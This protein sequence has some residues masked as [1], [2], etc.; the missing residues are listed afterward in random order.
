FDMEEP[1]HQAPPPASSPAALR[2]MQLQRQAGTRPEQALQEALAELGVTFETGKR[3]LPEV[4]RSADIVIAEQRLAVF[5]D[6][7]FWHCCPEHA[8][9]PKANADFWREKLSANV[10]RD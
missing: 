2:R 10:L 9:W 6:G 4:R 8:T 5:V 3:L 7:C 1:R